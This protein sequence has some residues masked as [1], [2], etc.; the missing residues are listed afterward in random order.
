MKKALFVLIF[1][2]AYLCIF[3]IL[4]YLVETLFRHTPYYYSMADLAVVFANVFMFSVFMFYR[5]RTR[6]AWIKAEAERWLQLRSGERSNPAPPWRKRLVKRL[7][8]LPTAI[9]L[10]SALFLPEIAGVL[11]HVWHGRTLILQR[12]HVRTPLTWIL[13]TDERSYCWAF[14]GKGIGRIGITPYLHQE[15]PFSEILFYAASDRGFVRDEVYLEK[16]QILSQ[17]SMRVGDRTLN[18]WD[19]VPPHPR[20]EAVKLDYSLADIGCE[21][22]PYD[23][24]AHFSGPRTDSELFYDTL[25]NVTV[26]K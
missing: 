24:W 9:V 7:L 3:A 15:P 8:W 18:C 1:W 16:V 5:A 22:M 4:L 10:A 11:S 17:R 2:V 23:F 12:F 13:E 20:N 25:R 26:T 14:I 19:I 21:S 6:D